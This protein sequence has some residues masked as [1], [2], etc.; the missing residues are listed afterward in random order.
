PARAPSWGQ[1][2]LTPLGRPGENATCLGP[3]RGPGGWGRLRPHREQD[4]RASGL[5]DIVHALL[6]AAVR[7]ELAHAAGREAGRGAHA[8]ETLLRAALGG[9]HAG[10]AV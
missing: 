4:A 6:R 7:A 2:T 10:R 1:A 3:Q 9:E 8:V 5:A